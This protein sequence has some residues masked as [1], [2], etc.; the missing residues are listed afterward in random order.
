MKCSKPAGKYV[1]VRCKACGW[2]DGLRADL[3]AAGHLSMYCDSCSEVRPVE[4]IVASLAR[5]S[6]K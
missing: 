1:P 3:V 6:S 2:E 4:L 5:R